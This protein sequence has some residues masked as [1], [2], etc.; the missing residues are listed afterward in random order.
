MLYKYMYILKQM[1]TLFFGMH[2]CY[3]CQSNFN[4]VLILF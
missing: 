2:F 4:F 1:E 3:F